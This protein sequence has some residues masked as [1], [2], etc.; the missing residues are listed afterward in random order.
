M[1]NS[2]VITTFVDNRKCSPYPPVKQ[3]IDNMST[4]IKVFEMAAT[5]TSVGWQILEPFVGMLGCD[6]IFACAVQKK[7]NSV[8]AAHS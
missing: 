4:F 5:T 6:Y 8:M 7:K 2:Y 3:A 1:Q